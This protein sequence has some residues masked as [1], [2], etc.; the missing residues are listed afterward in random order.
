[1][2]LAVLVVDC[3]V[4]FRHWAKMCPWLCK[5]EACT[6][7]ELNEERALRKMYMNPGA[8][9]VCLV[10]AI[11]SQRSAV[12][13]WM[14]QVIFRCGLSQRASQSLSTSSFV[15]QSWDLSVFVHSPIDRTK[16]FRLLLKLLLR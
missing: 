1:M 11:V 4:W 5:Y 13:K 3:P 8:R 10:I 2:S 16:H 12:R 7:A 14:R 6:K 9:V 15:L